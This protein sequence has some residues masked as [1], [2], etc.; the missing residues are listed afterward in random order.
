MGTNFAFLNQFCKIKVNKSKRKVEL[1]CYDTN[2]VD[3]CLLQD[4]MVAPRMD[5]VLSQAVYIQYR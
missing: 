2:N 3:F 4:M 1:N 5:Q